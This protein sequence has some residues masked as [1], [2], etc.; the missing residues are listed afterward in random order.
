LSRSK[1]GSLRFGSNGEV[2]CR[3][4]RWNCSK[5]RLIDWPHVPY[6]GTAQL[7]QISWRDIDVGL[8]ATRDHAT[9]GDRK[10]KMLASTGAS[11]A[12]KH[13][14]CLPLSKRVSISMY[15]AGS[16]SSRLRRRLARQS[17]H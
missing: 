12:S 11:E 2:A 4:W 10:L 8:A 17:E 13:L 1:P 9:C 5:P 14:I 6:R 15:R 7:R 3:I 16:G